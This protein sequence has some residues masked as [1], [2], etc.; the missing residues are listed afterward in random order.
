MRGRLE[1]G[2]LLLG[3]ACAA[4]TGW[5]VFGNP[6][7]GTGASA[8]AGASGGPGWIRTQRGAVPSS[9]APSPGASPSS[10][11]PV[12]SPAP[13]RTA[14][15]MASPSQGCAN[16]GPGT[17][18]LAGLT[19]VPGRTSAVVSWPAS[20]NGALLNYRLTAIPQRIVAGSQPP[21]RWQTVPAGRACGTVTA[22]VPGL[23]SGAP[24]IFSVD[25]VTSTY[26]G[27]GTS[28]VTIARSTVVYQ[29]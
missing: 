5:S 3:V 24:Y 20:G 22:T 26:N 17:G 13:V 8:A 15:G 14:G 12:L 1:I 25:A 27:S 29:K 6:W 28:T 4:F 16:P 11:A 9:S 18:G 23:A 10:P 2:V 21:L 19:V 7:G